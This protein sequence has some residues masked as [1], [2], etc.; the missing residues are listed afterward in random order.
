MNTFKSKLIRFFS[1]RYGLDSFGYFLLIVYALLC[2]VNA[3]FH[4]NLLELLTV[5]IGIYSL[6]RLMSRNYFKRR[7][8]NQKFLK[9][10][11]PVKTELKLLVDRVK[12]VKTSRFRKCPHC[13][14]IIK[15]PNKRGSHTVKCPKCQE[16]FNVRIL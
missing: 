16:R 5:C 7:A 9:I 11:L 14:A 13:K 8:E 3:V 1:G 6:W 15:L 12:F 4:F 10:W 2:I